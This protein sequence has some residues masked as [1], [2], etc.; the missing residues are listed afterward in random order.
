VRS[1]LVPLDG[2]LLAEAALPY[3]ESIARGARAE[4]VLFTAID[5]S[6]HSG[7]RER[8]NLGQETAWAYTYLEQKRRRLET[9]GISTRI[10]ICFGPAAQSILTVAERLGVDLIVMG[11]RHPHG[12][13][14]WS[15][16]GV[17]MRVV[18]FCSRPVLLVQPPPGASA[19]PA[20]QRVLVPVDGSSLSLAVMPLASELC[21]ALSA[22][23]VLL[24]VVALGGL[25]AAAAH[26][27]YLLRALAVLQEEARQMLE[28][29]AEGLG[30]QGVRAEVR[31]AVGHAI[32]QIIQTAEE[33]APSIIVLSSHGRSGQGRPFMGSVA[34]AVLQRAP[35]PCL[36]AKPA[37]AV[38][39]TALLMAG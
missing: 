6:F 22:T 12:P 33:L 32:N 30:R 25:A 39:R 35:V 24:H 13:E 20:L 9:M 28:E 19:A 36:L 23:A 3:A 27:E 10:E 8:W 14:P 37:E 17:C 15:C 7:G 11:G 31:V 21:R 4:V 5:E 2:S 18:E 1:L 38:N 16:G 34:Q 29:L 26:R